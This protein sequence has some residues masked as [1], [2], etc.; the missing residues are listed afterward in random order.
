M[1]QIA[2]GTKTV[3]WRSDHSRNRALLT[4]PGLRHLI[5][6]YEHT[7][8]R[9]RVEVVSVKLVARPSRID[10]TLVTTDPC[11]KVTLGAVEVYSVE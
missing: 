11:W 4:R 10:A 1:E 3:E 8:R 2:D 9:V 5:F 7:K 6:Y